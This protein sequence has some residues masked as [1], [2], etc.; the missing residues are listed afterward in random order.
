[1]GWRLALC[2]AASTSWHEDEDAAKSQGEGNR[3]AKAVA[4]FL[5]TERGERESQERV[6]EF[7]LDRQTMQSSRV[8]DA[9]PCSPPNPGRL[10]QSRPSAGAIGRR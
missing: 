1:M 3:G 2:A 8:R 9:K 7:Q 10:S 5:G 6:S 4:L